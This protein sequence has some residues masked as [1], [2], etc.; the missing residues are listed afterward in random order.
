MNNDSIVVGLDV[1]KKTI[2]V[3]VLYETSEVVNERMTIENVPDQIE[4]LVQHLSAKGMPRFCYEAGPCGFEVQRQITQL[5]K[6]CVVIAP[7]MTPRRPG[8]RVKTDRR[9]AEKLARLFRAGELTVIHV[10]TREEE[11]ARDLVRAREAALTDRLSAR[12]RLLKFLLRQGRAYR[13]SRSWGAAHQ[14]W[15]QAQ[16]FEWEALQKTYEAYLR[17]LQETDIRLGVLNQQVQDLSEQEP[18]RTPVRYLRCL[19]G[20]DTLSAL[21]LLVEVVDFQRFLRAPSFMGFTGMVSSED[22]SSERIRRG[23]ITKAGNNHIRRVLV[24]AAWHARHGGK[25]G[26]ELVERRKGCPSEV[27]QIAH[28]AQ[29]R[30]YRKYW[31]MAH[32]GK[33]P[34]VTTVA[35]ARELSGFVWA[36][37]QH[38]PAAKAA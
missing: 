28:R 33:L 36:I 31:R 27:V 24:E 16:R 15:L 10:P 35:C 29:D 37:A 11:A 26:K 18:Y 2:A 4:R 5:G 22:S 3:A 1:H 23:S 25:T 9:D 20:I 38:F 6:E 8:D 12:H 7:S 32:R 30:L 19:K 14:Q 34:S 17:A 13:E 21:T